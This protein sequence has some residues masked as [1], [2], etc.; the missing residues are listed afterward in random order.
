MPRF[1]YLSVLFLL[2]SAVI[3]AV[4][5]PNIMR[6]LPPVAQIEADLSAR[7]S[8]AMKIDGEVRLRF[9][10]RP[11][12]IIE[13]ASFSDK[14]RAEARFAAT[15]P[16]LVLDLDV[17]ELL[18]NRF[19]IAGVTLLNA[20][21]QLQLAERPAGLL[22]GLH[23]V[24]LPQVNMLD[25]NFRI[26]GLDPLRPDGVSLITNVSASLAA[27]QANGPMT[28]LARKSFAA[29]R[30]AQVRLTIGAT[31]AATKIDILFG[32]GIDEYVAFDG[33]LLGREEEWR[34][35]GEIELLSGDLLM[36][37]IEA[38]LPV[39][40]ALPGRRVQ[41]SGLVSGS[42]SGIRADSLEIEALNTVFPARLSLNW[43][44][45][46]GEVPLLDGRLS[47]GAVNLDLLSFGGGDEQT[48]LLAD[49]WS[50]VAPNL[51]TSFIVEATRFTLGGETGT[52]L[53]IDLRQNGAAVTLERL[54]MNLPFRSSLLAAG[55]FDRAQAAPRFDGSF[56]AR[57]SDALALLL[58]L[59]NQNE[60]D[61]SPFAEAVDEGALQRASMVGDVSFDDAGLSLQGLAGRLGDDYFS[62][63]VSLPDIAL[64]QG[65]VL[66]RISRLDL[67]DWGIA[68]T[69]SA[70]R[71][72][73]AIGLL[74]QLD[75]LLASLLASPDNDRQIALN[76]EVGRM[77]AGTQLI[78]P[79]ALRGNIADR[80]LQLT[81]LRLANFLDAN[82]SL[83]GAL[84]YD[85][86][87]SHGALSLAVQSDRA[88]WARG[89]VAA[90]FAP[91]SFNPALSANVT[92][93]IE[94][95]AP[96]SPDWPKVIYRGAGL[97]GGVS[98]DLSL[99]TPAR[100]PA[101]VEAGTDIELSLSGDAN[102]LAGLFFLPENYPAQRM[103]DM[104]FGL[105]ALGND[106]FSVAT[107]MRLADD[108]LAFNGALRGAAGGRMLTG[109]VEFEVAHFLPLLDESDSWERIP[110]IGKFQVNASQDNVGFSALDLSLG[111]GRVSGEGVLQLADGLPRL[112][113]NLAMQDIDFTWALPVR[114]KKAW[115]SVP[116]SWS[117][118]GRTNADIQLSA[119]DVRLGDIVLTGLDG[120][121]K[122]TEGVLEAPD[123]A[124]SL[125]GGTMT[126]N[127]LAEGGLMSPRFGLDAEFNG[128]NPSGF[129]QQQYGNQLVDASLSGAVRL[130]GRG[131][132]P[133][134]MMASLMGEAN[135][136]I[137]PG[138]LTFFDAIGFVDE[139]R[140]ADNPSGA[141][142]LMDKFTGQRDLA[143]AR[144]LGLAQ[145]RGG[146]VEELSTDFVFAEG[147]NEARLTAAVDLVNL[148]IN[149]EMKLYSMDRQRPVVWQLTGGL[150][151]PT[152]K[153]DASAFNAAPAPSATPPPAE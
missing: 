58:W 120:R 97:L 26:I 40:V 98:G 52:D 117:L 4:M 3:A 101:F 145:L 36:Q 13:K 59:G 47:T 66:F 21:V 12:I 136:E 78:G 140:A 57:S 9:V 10:P 2:L 139:L 38:R 67:A 11:Q 28:I 45:M 99:V 39:Q 51:A 106:L 77:F 100:S 132:S 27:Q 126:A 104:Q 113:A 1:P 89:F 84:N 134:A 34:L 73:G 147:L 18:Q 114:E 64:Q 95:T 49:I 153:A 7:F 118:L 116:I 124:L 69:G 63:D 41:F 112:N 62:A 60:I 115:R 22:A 79:F 25:S 6:V 144:G 76:I 143:F 94:L 33:F 55:E 105:N 103:G 46:E 96:D 93:D 56:S 102:S 61:F 8:A 130:E 91:L 125:L 109:G 68:E 44:R 110:A 92:M 65:D 32:I 16:R 29:G 128:V 24:S 88:D 108:R 149:A 127:L 72:S 142:S 30:I 50:G 53:A 80:Q 150:A 119:R 14:Q 138:K 5:V 83:A 133:R 148:L 35:D 15:I 107:D 129:L 111:A 151:K 19:V 70:G 152:I 23:G 122:L 81:Q 75:R 135:Y 85:A 137:A 131:T 20:D 90:R 141:T 121:L 54:S 146:V 87:P 71:E 31:A 17:L 43:P 74:Q 48:S 123:L 86:A 37:A 82:V 42:A